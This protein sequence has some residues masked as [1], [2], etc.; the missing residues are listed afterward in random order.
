MFNLSYLR[1]KMSYHIFNIFGKLI[2]GDLATK[3]GWRILSCWLMDRDCNR[4]IPYKVNIKCVFEGKLR[5]KCLINE[6][7]CS[8]Y[9]TVYIGNT[10][11]TIKKILEDHFSIVQNIIRNGRKPDLLASH[12]GQRLKYTMSCTDICKCMKF[13]VVN[14]INPIVAIK[15]FMK[16]HWII[17]MDEHLN[18]LKKLRDKITHTWTKFRDIQGLLAQK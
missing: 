15:S 5:N 6:V 7:K 18:I 1:V 16:P 8:I 17:F 12:Y 11:K 4:S 14:Q 10:E 13:K 9:E 2:N 3:I